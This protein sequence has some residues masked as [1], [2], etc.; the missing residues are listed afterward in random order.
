MLSPRLKQSIRIWILPIA[1]VGGIVF[2]NFMGAISFIS[3][4]LIGLMLFLTYCRLNP[5]DFRIT[6][7]SIVL[8]CVQLLGGIGI[9]FIISPFS[10]VLA[11]AAFICF[12]CP[13]ATAAPVITGMLGGSITKLAAFS[14]LSNFS[15]A[16]IAPIMFSLI[17]SHGHAEHLSFLH[18]TGLI[19]IKVVPIILGPLVLALLLEWISPKLHDKCASRQDISFY[20]WAVS[21]FIVV[22]N[23]VS[24][25]LTHLS[26]NPTEGTQMFYLALISLVI[27][28]IQFYV[29]RKIGNKYGDKVV[30]AQGLGQ[31]NTVLAIWMSLTFMNPL[32]SVGPAA[33]V[34]WQNTINSL[35]LWLKARRTSV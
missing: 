30:G 14:L 33:Y 25:V 28:L 7:F 29:G 20:V 32:S 23:A 16:L 13:T 19:S 6:K 24:Y 35:Q 3:P 22:G 2:H 9:Y 18:I 12:F 1:M 34:A 4:W 15:V 11:Q 27:C 8:L 21:L 17:G 5:K 10:D 31:K 26:T